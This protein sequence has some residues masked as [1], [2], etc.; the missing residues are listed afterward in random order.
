[1]SR[2]KERELSRLL[3]LTRHKPGGS[4]KKQGQVAAAFVQEDLLPQT[5]IVVKEKAPNLVK[6]NKRVTNNDTKTILTRGPTGEGGFKTREEFWGG[7]DTRWRQSRELV[8]ARDTPD[9]KIK[10]EKKWG[11]EL[12]TTLDLDN[13]PIDQISGK[14]ITGPYQ[15]DHPVPQSILKRRTTHPVGANKWPKWVLDK[16]GPSITMKQARNIKNE[17]RVLQTTS[18][19]SN[20]LKSNKGLMD[21]DSEFGWGNKDNPLNYK[22]KVQAQRYHDALKY[23]A[24][25]TGK[26]MMTREEGQKYIQMTGKQPTVPG[27]DNPE[28]SPPAYF[29]PTVGKD[30][31]KK[32]TSRSAS[33]ITKQKL[34]STETNVLQ[35]S[36]QSNTKPKSTIQPKTEAAP[37]TAK[38]LDNKSDYEYSAKKQWR[39]KVGTK[40]WEKVPPVKKKTDTKKTTTGEYEFSK[41][42]E[43]R[44]K[45]GTKN[46]EK[47]PKKSNKTTGQSYLQKKFPG[48][49]A[50]KLVKNDKGVLVT[51]RVKTTEE[52]RKKKIKIDEE[53][54]W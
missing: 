28:F 35:A 48:I 11:G 42:G 23:A 39:R 44:R 25:Q 36:D 1:M 14:P 41:K 5:K 43:W 33:I 13:P 52:N 54:I 38:S 37:S 18:P 31:P 51:E 32:L 53:D 22:P 21:Y 20:Q 12:I 15:T 8:A 47:V 9:P 7:F 19:E 49:N 45:I 34:V 29:P 2:K 26:H 17:R 3:D 10:T 4:K 16:H 30:A 50:P 40:T 6:P 24:E 27:W 46:W